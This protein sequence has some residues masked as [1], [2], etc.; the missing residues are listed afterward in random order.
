MVDLKEI[1]KKF[2]E[3]YKLELYDNYQ[4]EVTD[5]SEH[6]KGD[7]T[8][9]YYKRK[10]IIDQAMGLL[11]ENSNGNIVILVRKQDCVNFISSLI[12]EYVHLCDYNKLSNYR[13]DLDYRRLQEDF[14]FLFWTEFHATYLTYRYLINFDPAGLDVKNIQNE[15][16][17]DL[18]DYYS[19]SPKLDRHE[20][21]DKTV[22]SYGSYLALYDEFNQEV[23]LYPKHYYYNGQFLKIYNFFENKKTFEDFI[24]RFDD[25]KGLLLEI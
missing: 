1:I 13:N 22:R 9:Y 25:F 16:V 10:E 24:V 7:D 12:H 15:I 6:V 21:M 8:E 18:I 2:S 14:V 19:S 5:I 4:I 20:L 11:Y 3:E 17:S 23:T